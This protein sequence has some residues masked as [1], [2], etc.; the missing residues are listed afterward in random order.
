[1][2]INNMFALWEI[3]EAN[4]PLFQP[5]P[6]WFFVSQIIFDLIIFNNATSFDINQEHLARL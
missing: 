6:V 1:M 2:R 5:L 3:F 4:H